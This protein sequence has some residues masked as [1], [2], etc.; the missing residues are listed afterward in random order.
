MI[1]INSYM[2]IQGKLYQR[3]SK[4]A[5]VWNF[6]NCLKGILMGSLVSHG[7]LMVSPIL[8]ISNRREIINQ[9]FLV[10]FGFQSQNFQLVVLGIGLN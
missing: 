7:I 1:L 8:I 5:K 3:F 2:M 9:Y 4:R 10:Q 6:L